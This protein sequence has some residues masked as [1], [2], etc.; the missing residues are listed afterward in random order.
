MVDPIIS[1]IVII[2][3]IIV[4]SI[5]GVVGVGIT[6]F[7]LRKRRRAGAPMSDRMELARLDERIVKMLQK[8]RALTVQ[9]TEENVAISEEKK[10]CLVCKGEVLGFSFICKC[11]ATYCENCARALTNL[12]NVCWACDVPIDYSKPVKPYKEEDPR[13][14]IGEKSKEK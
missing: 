4:V 7:V 2:I 11:G 12:E 10:I 6:I 14:D 1:D 13:V 3:V 5:A 8:R 9:V